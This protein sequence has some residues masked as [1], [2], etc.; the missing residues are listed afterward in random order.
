MKPEY[1]DIVKL[2]QMLKTGYSSNGRITTPN[3]RLVFILVLIIITKRS[4]PHVMRIHRSQFKVLHEQCILRDASPRSHNI[5]R[6]ELPIKF[7]D[8][9]EDYCYAYRVDFS[10]LLFDIS[11]EYVGNR[12]RELLKIQH[13]SF[14]VG[15]IQ[16]MIFHKYN[17]IA[18]KS[19]LEKYLSLLSNDRET[20]YFSQTG[21]EMADKILNFIKN[22]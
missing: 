13:A 9:L 19:Q 11:S 21:I 1:E 22:D 3:E 12:F 14:S 18:Y 10:G 17:T 16:R 8:Y 4:V 15:D 7:H 5:Y 6:I 20:Y 2:T